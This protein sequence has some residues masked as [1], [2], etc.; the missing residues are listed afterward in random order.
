MVYRALEKDSE[1]KRA[2]Y[3]MTE[4]NAKIMQVVS[5]LRESKLDRPVMFI[6]KRNHRTRTPMRDW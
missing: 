2:D 1:D 4:C 6:P 5:D 3:W